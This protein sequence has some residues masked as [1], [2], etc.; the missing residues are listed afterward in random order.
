MNVLKQA[1]KEKLMEYLNTRK[2]QKIKSP[3]VAVSGLTG[4]GNVSTTPPVKSAV[5]KT[6]EGNLV[7]QYKSGVK[8]EKDG[9]LFVD[10]KARGFS[11]SYY[12]KPEVQAKVKEARAKQAKEDARREAKRNS[13]FIGAGNRRGT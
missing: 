2:N 9:V 1:T 10:G 8:T 3:N 6:G 13:G 4:D 11:K 7:S 12:E 5:V